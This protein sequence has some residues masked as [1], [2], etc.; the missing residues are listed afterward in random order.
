VDLELES[1]EEHHRQ[2]DSLAIAL[3]RYQNGSLAAVT[4][5]SS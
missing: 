5:S 3:R 2:Q 1:R 4:C